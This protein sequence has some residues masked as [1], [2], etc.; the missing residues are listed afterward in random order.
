MSPV[1]LLSGVVCRRLTYPRPLASFC[2]LGV[3]LF[4]VVPRVPT[5][6]FLSTDP[7][8]AVPD[9]SSMSTHY[10]PTNFSMTMNLNLRGDNTAGWIPSHASSMKVEVR[11][12]TTQK[13]IGE[14]TMNDMT[15]PGRGKK[16]FQLPVDFSYRSLNATGDSTFTAV[17]NACGHKYANTPRPNLVL[18]VKLSMNIAG[19]VGTKSSSTNINTPCPF[20]LQN[21]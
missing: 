11:E 20:E 6:A 17:H 3:T 13:K 7:L 16:V 12:L 15:F 1:R 8:Q 5:I 10:F 18:G 4:F 9:S 14:G 21:E 2:S 19:L